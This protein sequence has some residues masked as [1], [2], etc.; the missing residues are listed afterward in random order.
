MAQQ[1]KIS[2]QEAEGRIVAEILRNSD[3]QTAQASGGKQDYEIRRIVGCQN[4]NCYGDKKDPQYADQDY[5]REYIEPNQSSYDL[6]QQQLGQGQTYNEL[7]KANIQKNPVGATLAGAGMIGLGVATVG[8]IPSL[9]GMAAGGSIG[10]AVNSGAEY[11]FNNGQIDPVD[12]GASG[13]AGALTFG[14]GLLPGMLMQR[15][16]LLGSAV[17]GE[18]PNIGMAGAAAG[19]LVGYKAGGSLERALNV[20][21]NPW[22]RPEWVDVGFGMSKYVSSSVLPSLLGT[23]LG[24]VV[25]ESTSGTTVILFDILSSKE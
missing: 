1:L 21:M 14:T 18:N 10:A 3:Q 11:V 16:A 9:I 5:N 20:R 2:E 25:S 24:N 23:A 7:V 4:L 13:L 6:G 15:G 8:G 19:S 22:Y 17:K 12:A